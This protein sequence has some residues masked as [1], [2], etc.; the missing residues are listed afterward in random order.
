MDDD[1]VIID[2]NKV[3]VNNCIIDLNKEFISLK[4]NYIVKFD[5]FG[6]EFIRK[7]ENIKEKDL[8]INKIVDIEK[9][10]YNKVKELK[11]DAINSIN[12]ASVK[13]KRK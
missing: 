8:F 6:K 3:A 12:N 10:Y 4:I 11:N 7:F 2:E 9:E 1:I 5:L 13:V